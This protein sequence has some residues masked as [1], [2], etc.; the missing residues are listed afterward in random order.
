[1]SID[2]DL[3]CEQLIARLARPLSPPDRVA[4]P[5]DERRL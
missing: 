4:F 2:N 5:A 1:M 3:D